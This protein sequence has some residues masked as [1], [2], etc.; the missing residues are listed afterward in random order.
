[1]RFSE[2]KPALIVTVGRRAYAI[3]L[4][5]VA[6]TMRPLA[7]EAIAGMPEFVRGVSVIRGAPI[8]VV[9][10]KVLLE[11]GESSA[12][13]GRFVTVKVGERRVA[14]AVDGVVGLRNLDPAQIG[15]LPPLLRD[16]DADL[17]EAIGTCD[18]Q[19]L[20]VLRAARLVPDDVWTTLATEAAAR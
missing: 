9:D 15:E 4:Q 3:G 19:F 16:I 7:I 11:D 10:L 20:T 1:M 8:P 5:H 14:L 6:E 18:A 2:R 13:Y 17:V 12:V